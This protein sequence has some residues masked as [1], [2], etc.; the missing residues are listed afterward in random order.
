MHI[1]HDP[2]RGASGALPIRAGWPRRRLCSACAGLLTAL[3]W[4]S[5]ST[6]AELLEQTLQVPVRW[7][8]PGGPLVQRTIAV[9]VVREAAQE[10]RP[11]LILHHGRPAERGA[12][13]TL[14]L[15]D[16]PSNARYFAARGFVV[17]IPTRLG[18]GVSGGADVEDTGPCADKK[19]VAGVAAAVSQ[20][21]QLL[22][23]AAD[24][25]Y[26]DTHRGIVF[27]ESFGGLVAIAVASSDIAG[28]MGAVSIAG[29]DG[30]DLI[31]HIDEPCRPDRLR[32]AFAAYGRA[33]R[34]PTLWMYSANDRVWGS[35]YPSQW[36]AAFAGAGGRGQ[37]AALPADKNN[38]HFIFTRN[39]PAW[40]PT[41]ERFAA[42]LGFAGPR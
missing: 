9:K 29:G 4:A 36:Y 40:Q 12:F 19:F 39:P 23:F 42:E 15:Q 1:R 34:L 14:G 25:P 2:S 33:N 5:P 32:A 20:T 10:P 8:A 41:F 13:I 16:F 6:A 18:Y 17:L 31:H 37:F 21:R 28:V 7:H 30:G 11:F 38:G 27:G 35:R 22:S 24:L 26:V 3:V